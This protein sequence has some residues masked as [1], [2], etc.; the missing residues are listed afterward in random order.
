VV[1]STL[2]PGGRSSR[3]RDSVS[4][5]VAVRDEAVRGVVLGLLRLHRVPVLGVGTKSSRVEV[6]AP[7]RGT[8]L[9]VG[10]IASPE[11][12]EYF[13]T[14]LREA[15]EPAAIALVPREVSRPVIERLEK[16]GTE[17]LRLPTAA[18]TFA[19]VV[20]SRLAILAGS[21]AEGAGGSSGKKVET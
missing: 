18:E 5:G 10:Y 15:G 17:I 16:R 13:D 7:T 14:T 20:R 21:V 1:S 9:L 4:V 8:S 11:D 3:P 19:Q 2:H 6:G 12:A